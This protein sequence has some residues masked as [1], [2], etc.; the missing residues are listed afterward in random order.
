MGQGKEGG[1]W[2]MMRIDWDE[3]VRMVGA[4]KFV[5]GRWGF[6]GSGFSD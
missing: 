4:G 5:V 6:L 1:I 2:I 3:M